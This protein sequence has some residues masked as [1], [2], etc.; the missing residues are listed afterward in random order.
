VTKLLD[1]CADFNFFV[2]LIVHD[3]RSEV[4]GGGIWI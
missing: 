3:H 1:L 2:P 4:I